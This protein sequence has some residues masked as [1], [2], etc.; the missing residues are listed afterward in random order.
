MNSSVSN[1]LEV[2]ARAAP[3]I[4]I[5]DAFSIARTLHDITKVTRPTLNGEDSVDFSLVEEK[6]LPI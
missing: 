6:D 1:Y 2:I 4:S 5:S 3:S